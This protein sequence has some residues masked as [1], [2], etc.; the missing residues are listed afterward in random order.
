MPHLVDIAA[1]II[2]VWPLIVS[3]LKET[4]CK[5]DIDSLVVLS[6]CFDCVSAFSY[7]W[8]LYLWCLEEGNRRVPPDQNSIKTRG[9]I[10]EEGRVEYVP[11]DSPVLG[12]SWAYQKSFFPQQAEKKNISEP[13]EV[14]AEIW[15]FQSSGLSSETI[16]G[17]GSDFCVRFGITGFSWEVALEWVGTSRRARISNG[18]SIETVCYHLLFAVFPFFLPRWTAVFIVSVCIW[19]IH[20]I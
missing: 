15:Y 18:L 9:E 2:G 16:I 11:V 19:C 20:S 10:V 12:P 4:G 14:A 3:Y 6:S 1:N 5:D 7:Q 17:R 8:F 13:H